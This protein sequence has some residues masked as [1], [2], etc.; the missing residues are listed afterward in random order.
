M[1]FFQHILAIL[2][3]V[4]ALSF[5]FAIA[6]DALRRTSRPNAT[7]WFIWS[8]NDTLV[9]IASVA[10]GARNTLAVP[11]VY[12]VFGWLIFGIALGNE[13]RR[14]TRLELI[15]LTGAALG[16]I[17]YFTADSAIF[18]LVLA[19]AVNCIGGLP[20]IATLRLD[21]A[22]ECQNSWLLIWISG[23]LSLASVEHYSFA[24]TL[25]PATSF[26]LSSVIFW[27]TLSD[28]RSAKVK[29]DEPLT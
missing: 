21:P 8:L 9:M 13:R 22:A 1:E 16:W 15:C 20:T 11:A 19:V 25:F 5:Y 2:S 10:S 23:A 14:P 7:T 27:L 24:L 4:F 29:T 26:F 12:A 28:S 18:A 6:R 3:G 17:C